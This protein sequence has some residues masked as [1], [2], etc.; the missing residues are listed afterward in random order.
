M[1]LLTTVPA[2]LRNLGS[3]VLF[4]LIFFLFCLFSLSSVYPSCSYGFT[5]FLISIQNDTE[6]ID[7]VNTLIGHGGLDARTAT[8]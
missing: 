8:H 3:F 1:A 2:L 5:I 7:M 6:S 4:F